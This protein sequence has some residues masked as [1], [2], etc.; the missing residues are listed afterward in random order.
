MRPHAISVLLLAGAAFL[1]RPIL[2]EPHSPRPKIGIVLKGGGA[3]GFAH[4]GVLKVLERNRVPIHF[5]VG[6][7]MGAIVGAAYA[8]GATLEKMHHTL[9]TT[10]WNALFGEKIY[11]ENI[12]YRLKAGRGREIYGDAK[13]SFEEGKFVLP[14][15]VVEGQNIRLLFQD[16]F[17]NPPTP[18]DFDSLP[19]PYRAVAADVET[20]EAYVPDKGDLATMV[21]ASMSIPGAFS[22]VEIDGRLF[23][24]GG[25]T[26]NLPID[27]AIKMGCDVIIVVDLQSELAKRKDLESPLAISGQMISLLLMQNS[28]LSRK[29]VRQQ[30][31]VIEPNVTGYGVSDFPKAIELMSIGEKTA[32][33]AVGSFKHL[34]IPAG[35][36]N[37]YLSA[38]T[39]RTQPQQQ[40]QFIRLKNRSHVTDSRIK[41][42]MRVKAGD[43]FDPDKIEEDVQRIYQSGHFTTVQYAVV[44]EG[45]DSGIEIDAAGKEWLEQYVR[46]G[47]AFEDN[48]ERDDNFRLGAA[49][50]TYGVTSLD[51]YFETQFE[52]G[53]IPKFSAELYQPLT[54]DSP[55][56][57]APMISITRSSLNVSDGDSIVAEYERT[58]G[59]AKA[60]IG[61]RI[62]TMGEFTLDYTRGFGELERDIGD[63][64]LQ[65]FSSA[66][67]DLGAPSDFQELSNLVSIPWSFGSNTIIIRN[68]FATTFGDRPIE[69]LYS[70]G[71]FLNVSGT[72]QNS[73]PAS[74]FDS[75]GVIYF[76]RFSDVQNPFFDLAFFA[77]GSFEMTTIHN[78]DPRFED[79]TLINSGSVFVGAD[80]PLLP[81]Y[82]GFGISDIDEKSIYITFG[83]LS[84]SAR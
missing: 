32:E 23:V 50:R 80:T 36:Y 64:S 9:S 55:Y 67:D 39:G 33:A 49:F 12:D 45:G 20:G 75:G 70:L 47:M 83:R 30:D 11:R 46:L 15:G 71:G 76:R 48:L 58:E 60:A 53:K 62:S 29:L 7:S 26:D 1:C 13:F 38:R 41:E 6:T 81:V 52:L 79:Y 66:V 82:L 78:D 4:V 44:K 31:I 21:R 37:H 73:L 69:R 65:D 22:P 8:S 24:D 19:V 3:L 61:R 14:M 18:V 34:S 25:I 43:L 51:S 63:P 10:D 56:F 59:L 77:G 28:T 84:Q 74:N 2:A 27:V 42:L 16:L 72:L 54:Q 57:V 40:I 5:V 35:D 17:G 68:V